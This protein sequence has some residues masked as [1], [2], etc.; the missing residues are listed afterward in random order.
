MLFRNIIAPLGICLS[1]A[2]PGFA[3]DPVVAPPAA[4]PTWTIG[5]EGSPEFFAIDNGSNAARSLADTY[6]KFTVS[7]NF[8]NNFVGGIY[9][10]PT[11][12]TGGKLQYYGEATLG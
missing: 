1:M 11:F 7:H 6:F 9:I 4:A 2:T 12:K 8:D 10:Q 3:A 5:I